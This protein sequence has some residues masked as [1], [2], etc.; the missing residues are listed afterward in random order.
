MNLTL[1]LT[2]TL[3]LKAMGADDLLPLLV[4]CVV[5]AGSPTQPKA[6]RGP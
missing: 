6:K 2:L 4:F 5:Q 3:T 1:T